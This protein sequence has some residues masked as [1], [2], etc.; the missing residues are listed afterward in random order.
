MKN[1][2][3]ILVLC[4]VAKYGYT[5]CP[6]MNQPQNERAINGATT[7]PVNFTSS[8]S[9]VIYSWTNSNPGIG[10]AANGT[11]NLPSFNA[12]NAGT[13]SI[14][15]SITVTPKF[16]A[17]QTFSYTGAMQT[18]VVPAG[19][20]SIKVDVRGSKGGDGIYNQPGT[21]P[22]DLGG[23]GGRV[24]A[25]YPVTA[26]QTL[27]IF[28]G[29][30]GYNGGGNGGGGI[31]Q[32]SGGGA[33]DIRIGGVALTDRIVVA[34][35]GGG[36]GNNCSTNAEP[37]G[38]GGG[39]IGGTGFQCG[40]QTGTAV[41]QGGT[42]SAGGAAGTSP[43][44]AGILG[45]GGNAGGAGTAS[46]G[47][48]GGYYGGGG[49][50]YGGGGGGS[51][52]TASLA[53][54]VTHTQG[55]QNGTGQIIITYELACA[56]PS[57]KIF[58]YTIDATLDATTTQTNVSCNGGS[59]ATASVTA[60]GG[61]TPYTYVW[62]PSGGTAANASGLSAGTYTC[63]IR[64]AN[65]S[66]ISKNITITEPSA[67][68]ATTGAQTN[69]SC[70]GG[71]NGSATV[72]VTGG[73]GAYTY[74]WAPSGGTA[75]TAS[76]LAAGTYTVTI[77]DA[78][79]CQTTQSVTITEPTFL[80]ATTS[81]TDVLCNGGATGTASV[82]ASGG[83]AGYTY[84]WSPSGGTA[85]TATGLT[86]GNYSVLIT[87]AKGCITTKN[88]TINQPAVLTATTSQINATCLSFGQASVTVTG[89]SGSYTYSWLPSGGSASLATGLTAGNYSVT[90]T[91][92]NGCILTK[93]FTITS[94]NTLT[95]TQS[96]TNVLCNGSNTGTATVVPSG[97]PG[98]FTYVWSP[99]GGNAATATGLSAGNYSVTI[100]SSNGCSIVKNF[101]ITQ[102]S[103]ITATTSQTDVT[104]NGGTNGSA[105][106]N[107]SG[108]TGAYTY[109]WAPSGGTVATAT[110]LAAGTYTVTIKDA[111]LCLI[112]KSVT[113]TEPNA[114]MATTS[115]TNVTC[116]GGTNGTATVT[117]SGG[118]G[119]YTYSW[120]PSGG[121]GAIASG[122]S[123]GTY[124]V[125]IKDANLCQTTK[126]FTLT[127]PS[128][129]ALSGATLSAA[130][131]AINYQQT[132]TAT[133][134]SGTYLYSSTDV[135][136][137]GI[138]LATNGVLSGTP[139][140]AG[141]Y[142]F[143]IKATDQTCFNTA[144]ANFSITV[145]KG[146]QSIVFGTIAAKTYGDADFTL[147]ATQ[148]SAGL[149]I[150]YTAIDPTVVAITGNTAHIL[151]AGSTLITANQTGNSNY[152][153]SS[154]QQ[155]LTITPKALTITATAKNKAYGDV[156]PTLTF[157]S[158]GLVGADATTGSLSRSTGENVGN[159]VINQNTL[160]A[161]ANYTITYNAANLTITNKILTITAAAKNK[162]YGDVDPTLTFTSTG[163][164]GT[165]VITGNLS[166]TA[167]ENVG[168][169]SINQGS[170][171]AGANYTITYNAANLTIINK[172]LTISAAAKNK[173]YGDADPTLTYVSTG[174]VGADVIT[175]SLSRTV[176][177]NAGNYTINQNT[178]SAGAN[179]TITYNAA[180]LSIS[181]AALTVTA[182]NKQICQSS[183]LPTFSLTYAGFKNTDNAN[184]LSTK[185]TISTTA[186]S[187]SPSGNYVLTP[188]GGL[189][190]NYTFTYVNGTLTINALPQVSISSSNGNSISKGETLVL[191]ASGGTIYTW[192][193]ANGIISGQN[194]AV[195][196]VRPTEST[197][198]MVTASNASNCSQ[199]QS[200]SV[201]VRND[202]QAITTPNLLTPNG[203]GINDFWV[204]K[205]IDMY[206]NN[207]VTIFNASGKILYTKKG[208]SNTWDGTYNGNALAEGTYYFVIDF[209]T[210]KLKQKGFITLI[211]QQ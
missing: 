156:D 139:T 42:Q 28:V 13:N 179:Y 189:A 91:D 129:V 87:D 6:P 85:A 171:S 209:G 132:I 8:A 21:K 4:I 150:T 15:A 68:I 45:V 97:A 155:S 37:G 197:I 107:P 83:T 167:G 48:G 24:V 49:A 35:G 151:K 152:E 76:G 134:A 180:N 114:I 133:G 125:T 41:G 53:T 74:V 26:G 175:G 32:P 143:S 113:I 204:V 71:T 191:T 86:V 11:G 138:T 9:N 195:L 17:N 178:L 168:N 18:F 38:V 135:L 174:L 73:T 10:L 211:R 198:Y 192:S 117:P 164:V 95:A 149:T 1:L 137:P 120:A 51:S 39:L 66:E 163:L 34:G 181:K 12:T 128:A 169:Y 29:G 77:K 60:S 46:G 61:A 106:A 14:I 160:S 33:S 20:T 7:A 176:G 90:V 142:N 3:L 126:T 82:S 165:D 22:D 99:S 123:A 64:D 127:E 130:T 108:G 140:T 148:S 58:T 177:E 188:T 153:N 157:T 70:N 92:A 183:G 200:F 193:N 57:A 206:P 201:E 112:T 44:T 145:A 205:N 81:K 43:A 102:P 69:V 88:F 173:V 159:Y 116:N 103:A 199:S 2:L 124:T 93:N 202:F 146:S 30:I 110:G 96:Q 119:S 147:G 121:T 185:P 131:V 89:G 161:G 158:T 111:N 5:Q 184:S 56:L 144:T 115:Q 16:E 162:V 170:L 59:N 27:Y 194:S 196:T 52:Y 36:G 166:R 47:G 210:D 25:D 141:V 109:S 55:F 54:A 203:D 207:M 187:N 104:C 31:A 65:G 78:N 84:L 182:D 62:S 63:T 50:A 101:T 208:Y 98:P 122:L 72:N 186:T 154:V 100:T 75:A 80:T 118:T 172:V 136:P 105:T 94:T 19:V 79:L 190:T 23:N 40:N 67:L